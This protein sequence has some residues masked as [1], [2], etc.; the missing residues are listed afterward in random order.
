VIGPDLQHRQHKVF[1]PSASAGFWWNN[2]KKR[3]FYA[4]HNFHI[5]P[6]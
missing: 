5:S 4:F 6:V 3:V 2:N 1:D